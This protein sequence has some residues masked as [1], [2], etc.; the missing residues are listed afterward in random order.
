MSKICHIQEVA[1]GEGEGTG[2]NKKAFQ[3]N[4]V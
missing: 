1:S 2:G 4:T 3:V